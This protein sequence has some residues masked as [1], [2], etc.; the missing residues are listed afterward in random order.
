MIEFD[1]GVSVDNIAEM[2]SRGLDVAV[3]G[4]Y[5]FGAKDPADAIKSLKNLT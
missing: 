3:S 1:G 2:S 4:S 5:V